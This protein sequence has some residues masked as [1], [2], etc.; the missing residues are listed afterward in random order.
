MDQIYVTFSSVAHSTDVWAVPQCKDDKSTIK[1]ILNNVP[2]G[3]IKEEK[4]W[5]KVTFLGG[6][7]S[8]L[9]YYMAAIRDT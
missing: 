2:I 1:M 7:G 4:Y 6:L 3:I 5:I 9:R 8:G